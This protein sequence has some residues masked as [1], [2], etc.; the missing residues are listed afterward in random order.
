[1]SM[2]RCIPLA[3]AASAVVAAGCTA[4][5]PRE[6][7]LHIHPAWEA[8]MSAGLGAAE[9]GDIAAA[10]GH[11]RLA[12]DLVH[13]ER[14]PSEEHAFSAYHLGDL[15][16][17]HPA[18]VPEDGGETALALLEE[19]RACFAKTY[20]PDHP[21]LLPVLARLAQIR[22]SAGDAEGAAAA[23]DTA[24]RIAARFFPETHF[25]RER[26]GAARPS[27]IVHPL[28]ILALLADEDA[29]LERMVRS[30]D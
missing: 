15:M 17:R 11:Y 8:S 4:T 7:A 6:S 12:L 19:A 27:Q 1:M 3:C 10:A 21:V 28:E 26:F 24:D 14:L 16:Q 30:P 25:L 9:I 5:A 20:G 18:A 29:Q 13:R 23:R 2:L 22:E